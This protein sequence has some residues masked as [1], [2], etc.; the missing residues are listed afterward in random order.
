VTRTS[1]ACLIRPLSP[2]PV[3]STV[4]R[5]VRSPLACRRRTLASTL[6]RIR[7][8]PSGTVKWFNATKGYGFIQ[9]DNG[10]KDVFVHISAVERAG[11]A[12]L[13]RKRRSISRP[14]VS[15]GCET[16]VGRR[17]PPLSLSEF[18]NGARQGVQRRRQSGSM[19]SRR[20]RNVDVDNVYVAASSVQ[21][22]TPNDAEAFPKPNSPVR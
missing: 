11:L 5:G 6:L 17:R 4:D 3:P 16:M 9:P 12:G 8:M 19:S 18:E 2:Q 20:Q 10:G 22:G 14:E 15:A 21:R 7:P 1:A 13:A